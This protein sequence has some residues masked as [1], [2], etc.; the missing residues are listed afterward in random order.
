[1]QDRNEQ[2]FVEFVERWSGMMLRL[3]L[4]YVERR[5]ITEKQCR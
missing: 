4:T 5:P 3:A 2:A 1:V